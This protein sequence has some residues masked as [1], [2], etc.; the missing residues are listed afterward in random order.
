M[1]YTGLHCQRISYHC[2][3]WYLS[4]FFSE[5]KEC[6]HQNPIFIGWFLLQQKIPLKSNIFSSAKW[7]KTN[8]LMNPWGLWIQW[9]WNMSCLCDA[10]TY[11]LDSVNKRFKRDKTACTG[12]LMT[13]SLAQLHFLRLGLMYDL[14]NL[15]KIRDLPTEIL[16]KF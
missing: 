11:L 6:F 9:K 4:I 7:P 2:G 8:W 5:C 3:T 1:M 16:L 12:S 13:I 10:A 14:W 15:V